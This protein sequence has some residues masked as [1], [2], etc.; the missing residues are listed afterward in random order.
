M[1]KKLYVFPILGAALCLSAGFAVAAETPAATTQVQKETMYGSQ[2]MTPKE[3]VEYRAKLREAKTVQEREQIRKEHHEEMMELAKKKGITLSAEPPAGG[4]GMGPGHMGTGGGMGS[5]PG[6]MGSGAG[7][8]GGM[9][10][11]AG[12]GAGPRR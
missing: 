12:A 2:L 3:R 7:M 4:A 11:G 1:I 6:M 8:G 5:G 10:A 9:G